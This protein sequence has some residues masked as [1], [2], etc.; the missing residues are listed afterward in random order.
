MS[1]PAVLSLVALLFPSGVVGQAVRPFLYTLLGS[2]G[3]MLPVYLALLAVAIW[4]PAFASPTYF[5]YRSIVAWSVLMAVLVALLQPADGDP[6]PSL[7][8]RGGGGIVG[9][10]AYHGVSWAVGEPATVLVLFAAGVTALFVTFA[11]SPANLWQAV[12]TLVSLLQALAMAIASRVKSEVVPKSEERDQE[13]EDEESADRVSPDRS[14]FRIRLPSFPISLFRRQVFPRSPASDDVADPKESDDEYADSVEPL[15]EMVNP[16]SR[17]ILPPTDLLAPGGVND[18][19]Q[20]NEELRAR[21]IEEALAEFDVY[22][23]VVEINPGP[24]VTQFGLRPG[25][26][27]RKDRNGNVVRRDKIKV[28]E[29]VSLSNDLALALA[30]P[31]IRIEAPVPGRQVVGLEVPNSV[32]RVVALRDLL[33]S[34]EFQRARQRSKLAVGLGQDVSGR[35]VVIDLARAPHL[36]IAGATGSGKSVCVNSIIASLLL[37]CTPDDLRLLMVDPKRVEL[38][39][40]NGVPHLL[41]EV[42]VDT[43][44]VVSVLRWVTHEMDERYKRFEQGGVRNIEG[45]NRRAIAKGEETLHFLVVIIDELA[46]IMMMAAEEIEPALCR[47]AQMA[48]ATGIHLVVATQRPSVDVITGLIKANFP[49]RISFAVTS[50]VDSRTILDTVGAEKLLGRGD[51]LYLSSDAAKPARLQGTFVADGEIEAMVEFWHN[52]G[53]ARFVDELV[54]AP[55]W[56]GDRDQ[57]EELYDKALEI[58]RQHSRLSTSLL[59]RRL[60][61]GYPRAARLL[62]LLAERGVVAAADGAKPRDVV[63]RDETDGADLA[64]GTDDE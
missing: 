59:Q 26:R 56:Q 63:V 40:Y 61:V 20:P 31:S 62:E 39:G 9:W 23:Q 44:K 17:W 10:L 29:I 13:E 12:V 8:S 48:R 32:G 49:T 15:V 43:E 14:G 34:A 45:Y 11:V 46:D 38:T 58:A 19:V 60:R 55:N 42:V 64:T 4:R 47:L 24:T 51:M 54:H 22:A 27:E 2:G 25:F 57:D 5:G 18:G 7:V 37:H 50:Q 53:S 30:A 6:L 1:V 36:L 35:P 52:Q 33:Q 41:R 28:S 16:R 3:I 21:A